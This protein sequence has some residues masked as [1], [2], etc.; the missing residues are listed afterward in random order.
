MILLREARPPLMIGVCVGYHL[1]LIVRLHPLMRDNDTIIVCISPSLMSGDDIL[2]F[3]E[4]SPL[5]MRGDDKYLLSE[6]H[7]P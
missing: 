6:Y 2:M 4:I 3:C 5:L 7:L 1:L